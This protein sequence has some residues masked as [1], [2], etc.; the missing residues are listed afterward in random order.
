MVVEPRELRS[1]PVWPRRPSCPTTT[2]RSRFRSSADNPLDRNKLGADF[3]QLYPKAN[4][5]NSI[6]NVNASPISWG[7]GDPG[8]HNDGKDY[9]FTENVTFVKSVHTFKSGFFYNRDDKKQTATWPM[10]ASINFNSSAAMQMDT[11]SG[12]ANLMLGNFQS[13]TQNNA[14]IYPYFRFL[15][16]EAYAQDSWKVSKRVTLEYGIRFEHMVPTF[17]YTRGGTPGGEGTWKLYSVDL[18]KYNAAQAA[19][20]R[21]E[22]R[23]D[24]RRP[25]DGAVAARP[26]LRPVLRQCRAASLR[27]RTCLRRDSALRMTSSATARWRSARASAFS[28]NASARTTSTSAP[29]EAGRTSPTPP[30]ST[31]TSPISIPA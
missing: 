20:D 30:R 3:T 11:G 18:S 17:T 24:R 28:T 7:L 19:G 10:N 2:S 8:W 22:Y 31:A 14:A 4:L 5:T 15:A 16:Y 26:G 13:Y 6:P 9:A 12:L 1:R 21:S 27:P 23:Q 25:D 29:A